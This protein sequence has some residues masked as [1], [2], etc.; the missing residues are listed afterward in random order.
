MKVKEI[1]GEN[2]R[3]GH[4]NTAFVHII[5]VNV[6]VA[7]S[8]FACGGARLDTSSRVHMRGLVLSMQKRGPGQGKERGHL[9]NI[10]LRC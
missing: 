9:L 10:L 6:G 1:R 7:G 4:T 5:H 3:E 2:E 8:P